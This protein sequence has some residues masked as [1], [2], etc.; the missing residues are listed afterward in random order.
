MLAQRLG[1]LDFQYQLPYQGFDRRKV[2]GLVATLISLPEE[3]S[4]KST[5]L[6]ITAGGK[7]YN[8]VVEDEKA[9]KDLLDR[10]QLRKRV[11][12]IPLNKIKSFNASAAVSSN[13]SLQ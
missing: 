5:A 6:E 10:G 11:T 12:L 1:N 9:G 8:V 13:R 7:L 3:H 2:K 4:N